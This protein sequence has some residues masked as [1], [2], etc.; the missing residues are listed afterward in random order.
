VTSAGIYTY[1]HPRRYL[2]WVNATLCKVE[3]IYF[4]GLRS[5]SNWC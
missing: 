3:H 5:V 2:M 1:V 4:N